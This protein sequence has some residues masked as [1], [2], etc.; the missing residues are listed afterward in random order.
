MKDNPKHELL[1]LDIATEFGWCLGLPAYDPEWGACRLTGTDAEKRAQ[2]S[3]WLERLFRQT[4]V[5]RCLIETPPN[6]AWGRNAKQKF[7]NAHTLV[8]LNNLVA[9][10]EDVCLKH[11]VP[12]SLVDPHQ[13]KMALLGFARWEKRGPYPPIEALAQRGFTVT[14]H[15][16]ADAC[17]IWLF[18]VGVLH[19][20]LAPRFDPL[21]RK[22]AL[23]GERDHA[24]SRARRQAAIAGK[25]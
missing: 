7:T 21:A 14:N 2:L 6:P 8:M 1:A 20:E 19:P 23:A 12:V 9:A 18:G 17:A 4:R 5:G 24:E 3:R 13:W 11:R 15:N 10:A 22:V 25:R 16:A